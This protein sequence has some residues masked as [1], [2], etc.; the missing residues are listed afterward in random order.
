MFLWCLF[1][2]HKTSAN[3]VSP[4]KLNSPYCHVWKHWCDCLLHQP[5]VRACAWDKINKWNRNDSIVLL[6]AFKATTD[7]NN[8]SLFSRL[9]PCL[10]L[11]SVQQFMEMWWWD[12]MMTVFKF[13]IMTIGVC[14]VCLFWARVTIFWCSGQECPYWNSLT[15]RDTQW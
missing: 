3:P 10:Y 4:K 7:W 12:I 11:R 15:T 6:E 13:G 14:F 8:V 2:H 9:N 5:C 1:T